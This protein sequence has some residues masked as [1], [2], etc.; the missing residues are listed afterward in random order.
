[1]QFQDACPLDATTKLRQGPSTLATV[2]IALFFL[3]VLSN[4]IATAFQMKQG[5]STTQ[6]G[7]QLF[8]IALQCFALGVYFML[9]QKCR[10][11]LGWFC[12]LVGMIISGAAVALVDN[13]TVPPNAVGIQEVPVHHGG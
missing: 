12:F 1:M 6:T 10:A 9:Y 11:W 13:A 4:V 8:S 3:T 7:V 5:F 2:I